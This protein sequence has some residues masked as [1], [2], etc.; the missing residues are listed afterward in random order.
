MV[1]TVLAESEDRTLT[2]C[3]RVTVRLAR[4][5]A[6]KLHRLSI[7]E[8]LWK[9]TED[10]E[11]RLAPRSQPEDHRRTLTP[12]HALQSMYNL[13][14]VAKKESGGNNH[15]KFVGLSYNVQGEKGTA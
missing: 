11:S 8:N 3:R 2:P 1:N 5:S 12:V 9:H 6:S 4:R 10:G 15:E 7:I 13:Q 14:A